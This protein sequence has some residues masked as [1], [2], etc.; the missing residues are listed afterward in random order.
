[1]IKFGFKFLR[2]YFPAFL[3]SEIILCQM[4]LEVCFIFR[5]FKSKILVSPE[6]IQRNSD[7]FRAVPHYLVLDFPKMIRS[8]YRMDGT[9]DE[10]NV[11]FIEHPHDFIARIFAGAR[12]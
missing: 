7:D 3:E 8:G 5:A 1:M 11:I 12:V 10:S 9:E 6:A 4:R 2:L